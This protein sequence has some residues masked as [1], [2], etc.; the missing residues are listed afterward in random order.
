MSQKVPYVIADFDVQLASAVSA[1]ATSI[2][3]SSATDDDGQALPSGL[4]CFTVDNGNA[5]KEYLMGSLSGTTVSGIQSISRQGVA[6]ANVQ[7][8]HRAGASV[9]MT[10]FIALTRVA[11]TLRGA[12]ALDGSAP[13]AYDATPTLSDP[14]QLATVQYVLDVAT[15]GDLYFSAQTVSAVA[16]ETIAAGQTVYFK[17]SDQRWWLTDADTSATFSQVKLGFVVSG[18][19]AGE[20]VT[21]QLSGIA[22]GFSGL[23]AGTK[24]YL[25]NTAGAVSSSAG[26]TEVFFGVATSTTAI[27]MAPREIYMPSASQYAA[28]AGTTGTPSASNPFMTSTDNRAGLQKSMTAG[29]T[30]NGATLPVPVYQNRSDNEVYACD[31]ND[32]ARTDFLG[33]ATSNSTDGNAI[34]VQTSGVVSGFSGLAEGEKYYIQDAIGTIGVTPGTYP[35]LVGVAISTTELLIQKG[36]RRAAG[37]LSIGATV[38]DQVITTAFK[39]S[40]IRIFARNAE[41]TPAFSTVDIINLYGTSNIINNAFVGV[42]GSITSSNNGRLYDN[43]S[44]NDYVTIGISSITDTG[45]TIT[46]AET[47][48]F[49]GNGRLLWE[50]ES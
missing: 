46:L 40:V 20:G 27:L 38:S 9:I 36:T 4:Y 13:L 35:V 37:T 29:E 19:A 30:I 14:E 50:A 25:S 7:L 15:G 23:T 10:D 2:T 11:D 16:G 31:G 1:G 47:G 26:T 44:S 43:I 48:T 49:A 39:P 8:A 21:I 32:S 41:T 12:I 45:F 42:G 6:T 3:L 34:Y 33:F 18:G 5:S 28:L 17:E 22:E 24:Y